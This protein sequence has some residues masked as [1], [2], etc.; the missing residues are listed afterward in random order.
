ME[1]SSTVRIREGLT[2]VTR[3]TLFLLV[4]TLLFVLFNFVAR[5]LIV[6]NIPTDDWSAFSWSLTLAGF[7]AAFGT[8]GLPNAIA[9]SLPFANSDSER[10]TMVRGTLLLG[11]A[12]G[13]AV[14]AGL[15]L[16]GPSVGDRLGQPDIGVA[17]QFLSIAVASLIA[18]NL[19]ASI[20][21]GYEDVTPNALLIQIV[22]PIL[23]VVFLFVGLVG[24]GGL[25][26]Q[27]AL[28]A[29]AASSVLGLGLA[30]GYL[31][32]RLPRR[33][34]PGTGAPAALPRL[35]L[36]AG[37]LFVA[38]VLSS[39]TGNG[40]TLVLGVYFPVSVGAYSASL[41]LSRLLQ[42]GVGAAA[43]IFLPVTTR[44]FRAGDAESIRVTY[45]TVT[46]WL[47]LFSLPLFILF[48]FLPSRSLV[49]V[50]GDRY[51]S[52][53]APLQIAVVGA[54]ASTLFGPGTATQVALGQTRLVAYNSVATAAVDVVLAFA[55]IPH[56]GSVGA[57]I[58]WATATAV[59]AGLPLLELALLSGVHPFR[60][61]SMLPLALT[62][63][64][65]GVAL[66]ILHPAFPLWTLPLLGL[67]VAGLFIALVLGT[68]SIDR[69]DRLLLEVVEGLLGRPLRLVR[70]IGGLA[71]HGRDG[72]P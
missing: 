50:Y 23:F 3:G 59:G 28:L 11:G 27:G 32:L 45:A 55:L 47:M 9:R 60:V 63:I 71:L 57:A 46:K 25:T 13:I 38:S 15:F 29:Y 52:I 18:T 4:A 61:H 42:V 70:R 41:T 14:A 33:L 31:F 62:G 67:G 24:P 54:F 43:Y 34:G 20:F 30:V 72:R 10:R 16:V 68:R 69:G 19:I 44:L 35:L 7:L 36:F 64:P 66:A 17:L 48:F 37:P 26:L 21:Q 12:A 40:D 2:A 8:L 53:I 65:L 5:V 49:F 58:A 1:S 6:R 39:L 56:Y 51:G 22:T